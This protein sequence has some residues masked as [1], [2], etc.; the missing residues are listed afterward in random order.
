MMGRM[1]PN[2]LA[3]EKLLALVNGWTARGVEC[4]R[5]LIDAGEPVDQIALAVSYT[6]GA[7]SGQLIQIGIPIDAV[8]ASAS[9]YYEACDAALREHLNGYQS[10]PW[11][12]M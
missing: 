4:V 10:V 8:N 11:P 12:T 2:R 7:M 5:A 3:A 1:T 6:A 9:T